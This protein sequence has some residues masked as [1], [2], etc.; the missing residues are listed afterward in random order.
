[1]AEKVPGWIERLLLPRLS[2]IEG[3]LK[4]LKGELNGL[5]GEMRGE[6]K[7]VHSETRRLDEKI[8]SLRNETLTRFDGIEKRLDFAR[9]LGVLQTKVTE[10]E[11]RLPKA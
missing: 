10:L 9:D 7:A 11:A 5:R 8:D 4:A 6:F 2:S 1:M 3:E